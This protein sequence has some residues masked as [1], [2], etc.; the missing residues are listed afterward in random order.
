[1]AQ[2]CKANLSDQ[3][4]IVCVFANTGK[5]REETLVFADQ[6]DKYFDLNLVWIEAIT[7]PQKGKGVRAKVVDFNTADRYGGPF[8]QF[9]KKHGIP[10][11]AVPQCSRELKA[12]AISSYLRDQ[13]GWTTYYTAIGIR[14]DEPARLNWEYAKKKKIIY[15]LATMIHTV[16][17]QINRFWLSMPF[18]LELKGYEGNCDFCWKKSQRKLMTIARENPNILNWWKEMEIKYEEFIPESRSHNPKIKPPIRFFR[19]HQSTDDI[20]EESRFDFVLAKDDSHDIDGQQLIWDDHLDSNLGCTESCE[21][22]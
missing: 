9:I 15:P 11:Q 18:D 13:L 14:A 3:Y 1:M 17:A 20:L 22:F 16:K 19:D 4:E 10:N 2:W 8:E 6:C 7:N 21:A 5:E 12:Y